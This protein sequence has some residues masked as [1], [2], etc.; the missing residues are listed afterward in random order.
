MGSTR[1]TTLKRGTTFERNCPASPVRPHKSGSFARVA[2]GEGAILTIK[3][4]EN[5]KDRICNYFSGDAFRHVFLRTQG[6]LQRSPARGGGKGGVRLAGG[7]RRQPGIHVTLPVPGRRGRGV[8]LRFHKPER[9]N[10]PGSRRGV[11]RIVPEQRHGKYPLLE[12]GTK[13]DFFG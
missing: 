13:G 5:E 2:G 8:A 11:W 12:H 6:A 9:G 3:E 7:S 4:I 10:N 1:N